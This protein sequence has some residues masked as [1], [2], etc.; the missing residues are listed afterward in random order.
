M[1]EQ[2]L[3]IK[4]FD[5]KTPVVVSKEIIESISNQI[6]TLSLSIHQIKN[7]LTDSSLNEG[8]KEVLLKNIEN[9]SIEIFKLLNYD[10]ILEREEKERYSKIQNV[11]I[12]NRELR[13]QLGDK[14]S[15]ED[16][17]EKMKNIS[18]SVY[19]WWREFGFGHISETIFTEYGYLKLKLSGMVFKDTNKK[20]LKEL[21][22]E[23]YDSYI[24]YNDISLKLLKNLLKNK[25]PSGNINNIGLSNHYSDSVSDDILCIDDI[26]FVISDLNDIC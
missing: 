12:L 5:D 23:I 13:K 2:K 24:V 8:Y 19:D 9:S 15:N 11:K 21:G 22:F 7:K 6:N 20:Y 16:L 26:E 1:K 10:S 17:R 14:V 25:Y 3:N 18:S 4:N